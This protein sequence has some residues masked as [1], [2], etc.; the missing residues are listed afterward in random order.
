MTYGTENL[1]C[2]RWGRV[3]LAIDLAVLVTACVLVLAGRAEALERCEVK[4]NK[5]TGAMEVDARGLDGPLLWGTAEG[6]ET[7]AF[8]DQGCLS[9][10][11]ARKC[12]LA[13]PATAAATTPP[14][15]GIASD[16]DPSSRAGAT[17]PTRYS[18]SVNGGS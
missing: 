15:R 13:D 16:S 6:E 14:G 12:L 11:R 8:Y 1:R 3:K 10:N 7:S 2:N 5:D 9:P 4:V 17:R 18:S